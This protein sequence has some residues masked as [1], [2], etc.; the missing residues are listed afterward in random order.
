M[1]PLAAEGG[2]APLVPGAKN[3]FRTPAPPI[4][5]DLSTQRQADFDFSRVAGALLYEVKYS[6][7]Y[8]YTKVF[9]SGDSCGGFDFD[10]EVCLKWPI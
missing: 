10:L 9:R 8:F 3:F 2:L 7:L 6:A 4:R 1:P 5:R